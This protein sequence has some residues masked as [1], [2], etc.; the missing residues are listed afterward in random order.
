M[1]SDDSKLDKAEYYRLKFQ[2]KVL[3]DLEID[4]V[5]HLTL[6]DLR[7][8]T[9]DEMT[10]ALKPFTKEEAHTDL[11]D[12]IEVKYQGLLWMNNQTCGNE[13]SY[14][15]MQ[16]LH[17]RL[18]NPQVNEKRRKPHADN[19]PDRFVYAYSGK[20]YEK[21]VEHLK[22]GAKWH[23]SILRIEDGEVVEKIDAPI[24]GSGKEKGLLVAQLKDVGNMTP[25]EKN[26]AVAA[27]G[28]AFGRYKNIPFDHD[29]AYVAHEMLQNRT[30]W[31][32][33]VILF[34]F[35]PEIAKG[36]TKKV[37]IVG[38]AIFTPVAMYRHEEGKKPTSI[39]P[40]F[41][42]A[43]NLMQLGIVPQWKGRNLGGI[44]VTEIIKTRLQEAGYDL[45]MLCGCVPDFYKRCGLPNAPDWLYEAP[46]N[47]APDDAEEDDS[48]EE[49]NRKKEK[50]NRESFFFMSLDKKKK[51]CNNVI[52]EPHKKKGCKFSFEY[53][54]P[55]VEG[56]YAIEDDGTKTWSKNH[57]KTPKL[58]GGESWAVEEAPEGA[59]E[60]RDEGAADEG[61]VN[62]D[63]T[64]GV[65]AN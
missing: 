32:S 38:A 24:K 7:A 20:K 37:Y 33:R 50:S 30:H 44:A 14:G 47:F 40:R 58:G 6:K 48:E 15:K 34:Q 57:T 51:K 12:S 59:V 10:A 55:M 65:T 16:R 25:R 41:C 9:D 42:K 60:S 26:D 28:L 1:E 27:L 2:R 43:V 18:T 8:F 13:K 63:T 31:T 22:A 64:N 53:K 4:D 39:Q 23:T 11:L 36:N 21:H 29:A 3:I 49:Y 35:I 5:D 54:S 56:Y 62:E 46:W 61:T 17:Y 19:D 45:M 52:L